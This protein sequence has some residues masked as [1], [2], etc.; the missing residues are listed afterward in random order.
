MEA[1]THGLI[2][3][4]K[5]ESWSECFFGE[6]YPWLVDK[7]DQALGLLKAIGRDW[8]SHYQRWLEWYRS[9]FH[10]LM[11]KSGGMSKRFRHFVIQKDKEI[12]SWCHDKVSDHGSMV[13]TIDKNMKMMNNE[14]CNFM[15]TLK[16]LDRWKEVYQNFES[17]DYGQIEH[18]PLSRCP[19]FYELRRKLIFMGYK[20][21]RGVGDLVLPK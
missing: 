15:D 11:Q 19:H 8:K 18:I 4:A 5:R 2:G 10:P 7:E 14:H 16:R 13:S 21:G 20:D 1:T 6:S 12:G 3:I 17:D 9:Y